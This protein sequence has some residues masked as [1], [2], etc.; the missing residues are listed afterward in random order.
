MERSTE[1]RQNSSQQKPQRIIILAGLSLLSVFVLAAAG[2]MIANSGARTNID[3]AAAAGAIQNN[4][5]IQTTATVPSALAQNDGL[6]VFEPSA[7]AFPTALPSLTPIPTSTPTEE[8]SILARSPS[9]PATIEPA[10]ELLAADPGKPL[11]LPTPVGVYSWTLQ[12]PIIMYHYISV[13]PDDADKYR[14]D[15][16]V[17]PAAFRQQMAYLTDNGFQ[18]VDLYDLSLAITAKKE[19]PEK[20]VILTFDDGYRDNYENAFPVLQEYGMKG[21][22]FVVTQF[23]DDGNENY[24]SWDMVK[25]MANAG[26]RIE[27]HSKT[28]ADL[29]SQEKDYIVYEVL[30]SQETIA[31]H[32]GQTPRFFCYP[33]GSF[34]EK[35]IEVVSELDFWGAVTTAGGKWHGYNERYEWSRMRMRFTTPL[36][37]FADMVNPGDTISGK[38][39][40][41]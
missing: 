27:P 15:L 25:E 41:S 9:L 7:T 14:T 23:I 33:G 16:S 8:P 21:T 30:G 36:A 32:I 10:L 34:D 3:H 29:S 5:P 12:V 4:T 20:P 24:L 11:P 17:S 19:L 39:V 40:E 2:A 26:M 31:A 6:A 38:T 13:P 18:T 28:H 1:N 37:E 22:F 35:T